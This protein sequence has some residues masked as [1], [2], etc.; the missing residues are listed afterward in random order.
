MPLSIIWTRAQKICCSINTPHRASAES[1]LSLSG[2]LDVYECE[3][4][5]ISL[6]CSVA[7][8]IRSRP[9]IVRQ[10]P[11]L[12]QCE[13]TTVCTPTTSWCCVC[14]FVRMQT[15]VLCLHRIKTICSAVQMICCPRL[16]TVVFKLSRSIS[17]NGWKFSQEYERSAY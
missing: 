15:R 14:S 10:Q 6:F 4:L 9:S 13:Y 2:N 12:R 5:F 3:S 1:T 17:L 7:F 16:K 8:C 11:P